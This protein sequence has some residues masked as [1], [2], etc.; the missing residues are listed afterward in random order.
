MQIKASSFAQQN[1]RLRSKM[2][3]E[4]VY[5]YGGKAGEET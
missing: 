4:G 3:D 2:R 1:E 5:E